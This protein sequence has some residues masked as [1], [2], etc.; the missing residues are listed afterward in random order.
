MKTQSA[1]AF[2]LLATATSAFAEPPI[3]ALLIAGGCCHDYEAQKKLISEGLSSRLP[4]NWTI[5]HDVN[6]VDGKDLA[7]SREHVSSAYSKD[8]WAAGYDVVVHDDCYGAVKDPALLDRITKA[9]REQQV[10]AMFLHCAMHSYRASEAV[11]HWRELIGA[12]SV[13][14]DKAVVFTVKTVDAKHPVISGFPASWN[15]PEP[16]ELYRIEKLWDSATPLAMAQSGESNTEHPVVWVN[17]VG[18]V[19]TFATTLGHGNKTVGSSEYLDLLGRGMLWVC[20]KLGGDG[21]PVA[22]YAAPAK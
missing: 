19:R 11:G 7:T 5:I 1:L 15:T 20:G 12:Q 13:K 18:G 16:D 14:H 3:R 17:Q 4:V 21:K 22:G 2:L 6:V 8:D 10:P 9:H